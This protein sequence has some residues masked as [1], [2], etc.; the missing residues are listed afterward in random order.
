[1]GCLP[2]PPFTLLSCI[3]SRALVYAPHI[4]DRPAL[5][6]T[7]RS[8]PMLILECVRGPTLEYYLHGEIV[9]NSK[10]AVLHNKI[11]IAT[12]AG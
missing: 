1:M 5:D 2:L 12:I 9:P 10:A 7:R 3:R 4:A 6:P 11:H 8:K